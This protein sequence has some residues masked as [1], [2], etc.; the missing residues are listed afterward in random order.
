MTVAELITKFQTQSGLTPTNYGQVILSGSDN[1]QTLKDLMGLARDDEAAVLELTCVIVDVSMALT[2][3]TRITPQQRKEHIKNFAKR[4]VKSRL[5]QIAHWSVRIP[6]DYDPE[7]KKHNDVDD[8]AKWNGIVAIL[9]IMEKKGR[10]EV[11]VTS[12]QKAIQ[13]FPLAWDDF[14][15]AGLY[16][17]YPSDSGIQVLKLFLTKDNT[18]TEPV[19]L[20]VAKLYGIFR[21][22][23]IDNN[24]DDYGNAVPTPTDYGNVVSTT[25]SP[26]EVGKISQEG[27]PSVPHFLSREEGTPSV[28][29]FRGFQFS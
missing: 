6:K 9:A 23:Q 5:Y 17:D 3:N 26:D 7:K 20:L 8:V 24:T 28:L 16:Y 22:Q 18:A 4:D 13:P 1:K 2:M 21:H 14:S 12:D 29:P 15:R 27:T 19:S 10:T 25:Q 11:E